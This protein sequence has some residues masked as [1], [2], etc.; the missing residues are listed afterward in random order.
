MSEGGYPVAVD[1]GAT[2]TVVAVFRDGKM[3]EIDRF[4]T[5]ERPESEVDLIVTS[6]QN[7]ETAAAATAVGIGAPGPLDPIAGEILAPPNL[8]GW[9]NF[10]LTELLQSRL[11]LPV[12]LEN[13]ANLGALGEATYGTGAGYRSIFYL[14]ISTGIGSGL[15]IDGKI[16]GGH[17]GI[18]GEV[19]ALEP[20][21]FYG[22]N[23][24][25]NL[26]DLASGPGLV[27]C[28]RHRL[29]NGETSSLPG[30]AD[31]FDTP[32]LLAAA[33]AGDT[34]ALTTLEAGRHAI[35]G[36]LTT[37]L[38]VVA[39]DSI[40]L[41]GGLCTES[42]WF[43]DPVRERVKAWM[44][45]PELAEVPIERAKLWDRAVLYGAAQLVL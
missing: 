3:D 26:N 8:P 16:F 25:G 10:P 45:I 30:P 39:P 22:R 40:V 1:I 11:D 38:L 23:G 36:L 27:R 15:V 6:I 43:V 19:Y 17:R 37:V 29:A 7:S 13:D 28:A 9:R 14:T 34:V 12:R 31:D 44:P 24:E 5:P 41:A 32:E 33:E 42:R 20:G 2:K 21:H 4:L 18:A 35:A